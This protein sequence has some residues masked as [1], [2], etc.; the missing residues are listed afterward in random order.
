MRKDCESERMVYKTV[1]LDFH[2]L[3]FFYLVA[4]EGATYL[5]DRDYAVILSWKFASTLPLCFHTKLSKTVTSLCQ[6]IQHAL[7]AETKEA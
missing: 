4:S 7:T 5:T 2:M 1:P 6:F 3:L